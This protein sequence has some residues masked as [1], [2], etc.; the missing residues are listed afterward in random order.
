MRIQVR[1][2]FR[3][4]GMPPCNRGSQPR[5]DGLGKGFLAPRHRTHSLAAVFT[6][7]SFDET[8]IALQEVDR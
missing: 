8:E 1:A 7:Q 6:C 4:R 3:G 5:V 2:I